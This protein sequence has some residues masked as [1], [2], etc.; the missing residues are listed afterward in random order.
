MIIVDVQQVVP[1]D[2]EV[3]LIE[4]LR[5][6]GTIADRI[7]AGRLGSL[8]QF[9]KQPLT[10]MFLNPIGDMSTRLAS[11]VYRCCTGTAS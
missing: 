4:G 5:K 1:K 2:G 7:A 9:R 3:V 6:Q 11:P 10:A 8:S